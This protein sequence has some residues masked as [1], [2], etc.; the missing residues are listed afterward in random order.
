MNQSLLLLIG[1]Q[2][3]TFGFK[4]IRGLEESE[5]PF[6]SKNYFAL[7]HIFT[8]S[9]SGGSC[10]KTEVTYTEELER[11]KIFKE[12]GTACASQGWI[13]N[14]CENKTLERFHNTHSVI[15]LFLKGNI[16]QCKNNNIYIYI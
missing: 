9:L 13:K 2:S 8:F 12:H 15:H 16:S 7:T 5:G 11:H 1:R 14:S 6:A 4:K 3:L 10:Q